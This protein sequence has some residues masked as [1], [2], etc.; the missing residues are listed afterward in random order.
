MEPKVHSSVHNKPPLEHIL[1]Q[2]NPIHPPTELLMIH[3]HVVTS[4][5][6]LHIGPSQVLQLNF[7]TNFSPA[8]GATRPCHLTSLNF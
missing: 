7:C 5:P 3:F 1:C 4:R 8:L 2:I 6:T